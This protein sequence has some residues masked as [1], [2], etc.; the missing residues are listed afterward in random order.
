MIGFQ[1]F[2]NV[3]DDSGASLVIELLNFVEELKESDEVA[4]LVEMEPLGIEPGSLL[5]GTSS[6]T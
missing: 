5:P 6:A 1:V 4:R 2:T 3:V